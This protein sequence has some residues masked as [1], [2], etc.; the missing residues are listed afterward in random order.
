MT[1]NQAYINIKCEVAEHGIVTK[2]AMRFYCESKISRKGFNEAVD[3]GKNLFE[4]NMNSM[5]K[6]GINNTVEAV[7]ENS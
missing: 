3:I 7:N 2:Q 5:C 4:D 1:K 6:N